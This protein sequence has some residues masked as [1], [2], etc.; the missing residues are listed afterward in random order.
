MVINL[1]SG[2]ENLKTIGTRREIGPTEVV[3][4]E[5]VEMEVRRTLVTWTVKAAIVTM[6]AS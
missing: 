5:V 3:E 6:Y 2:K 1:R 4:T